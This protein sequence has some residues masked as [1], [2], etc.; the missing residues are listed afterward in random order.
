MSCNSMQSNLNSK[1]GYNIAFPVKTFRLS[2]KWKPILWSFDKTTNTP[3]RTSQKG[4]ILFGMAKLRFLAGLWRGRQQKGT[5]WVFESTCWEF[6]IHFW[7]FY[8]P[9]H[10]WDWYIRL[11][12][13]DFYGKCTVGQIYQSHGCSGLKIFK[14]SK[15]HIEQINSQIAETAFDIMLPKNIP[16]YGWVFVEISQINNRKNWLQLHQCTKKSH[17][18][19]ITA[20]SGHM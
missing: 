8:F 16:H 15:W 20:Q 5:T 11:H 17:H 14:H 6:Q 4:D 18:L 9:Y 12:L 19:K 13:V 10:P 7:R 3:T 1:P 2:G